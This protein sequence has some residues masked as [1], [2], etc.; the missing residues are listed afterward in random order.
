[1]KNVLYF[2][3][4]CFCWF[5][6]SQQTDYVDFKSCR[7]SIAF[8][9]LQN[10][11]VKGKAI[12]EL[13]ILK[14]TDS[15]FLDAQNF[16]EIKYILNDAIEGH[17]YDG[18]HLIVKHKFKAKT[19]HKLEIVWETSPKKAMYFIDCDTSTALSMT[20]ISPQIWTQGQGK[21]TS[22]WLPSIDDMNDKIEFDLNITFYKYYQ[23]IANG[24][25]IGK[26][27]HLNKTTWHY[28]MRK[29]MSSYLVALAIGKYKKK[30]EIAKSGIP[31]E[32][33]Y[34]PEDSSKVEPTYRYTKQM[35]DFLEDEIGVAYPWQNYKQV[36]VKDFLY[37]G[38]ENTSCTIFSDAFMV[39]NVGFVDKNYV[40]VNA[41]EL[42][43]QWFG[44]LVTETSGTHHWL[45]EG[46][47]TYYSLLA[48]KDVFGEN[49]YYWQLCEYAQEL[50]EQDK[51]GAGTSL[52]N[53]KASSTTFYKRGAWV[54]HALREK[55]GDKP[56]KKA[57]KNYLKKHKFEN[58]ETNDFVTEVEK[59]SKTDLSEFVETWLMAETFN[60]DDAL[61]SLKKSTYINEYLMVDCE[62][63]SSKC[64]EYLQSWISDEAKIK[65][66]YQ[67]P[68][69]ITIE[70]FKNPLK[71]RQAIAR[72][73]TKIPPRLQSE[74]E[75]LLND[76]SYQTIEE[77][78]FNLWT[79][80]PLNRSKYLEK[81]EHIIGFSNKNIRQLW[82][83]L[84][85]VTDN[86]RNNE[87]ENYLKELTAYS[88]NKFDAETRIMAFKYLNLI[89]ACETAC[90]QNLED[91]KKHHSWQLSKFAKT[92][93]TKN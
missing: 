13:K 11:E 21:Y 53:P 86:F 59:Y 63:Y 43:H 26:E 91:A 24:K 44:D 40:N 5:G 12:Y 77:A 27:D 39:D 75:E 90:K 78:L 15:I 83:T 42:A 66:I 49:H 7:A 48:E 47:A 85:L 29:P 33:Y 89:Q 67:I 18:K 52:L 31:L 38:M 87:K 4:G 92:F 8:G 64:K 76:E 79:N 35:F 1:M 60:Y 74:Y 68:D 80:F 22:N 36:P 62:V 32:M 70:D 51:A 56:F 73:V 41:H 3:F 25:L 65:V 72:F 6:F 88:S 34:Y 84:A 10:K 17:L 54:L 45:Q 58:V 55:V 19:R 28:D 93:L 30:V 37:A 69:K 2:V 46:F 16:S 81:T 14:D 50:Y 9:N 20:N 71:V 23:V 61:L 57:L 82:L